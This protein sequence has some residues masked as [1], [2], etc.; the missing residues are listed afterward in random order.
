MFFG[1][2][3]VSLK[4]WWKVGAVASVVNIAIWL[5]AGFAWWKLLGLW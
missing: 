5:T 4:E 1:H 3:Y 2:G